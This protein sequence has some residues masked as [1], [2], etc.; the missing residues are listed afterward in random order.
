MTRFVVVRQPAEYRG[1]RATKV[2][3]HARSFDQA[4]SALDITGGSRMLKG[5]K[6]QAILF[7]PLAGPYM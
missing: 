3:R 1:T 5:F 2:Q 6:L 4:L 7:I